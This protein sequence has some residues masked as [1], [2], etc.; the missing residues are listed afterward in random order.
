MSVRCAIF[1]RAGP[2]RAPRG[3]GA[4]ARAG[5]VSRNEKVSRTRRTAHTQTRQ[6]KNLF[7]CFWILR[8]PLFIFF[9]SRG[10]RAGGV[11]RVVLR[12]AAPRPRGQQA[13]GLRPA[14]LGGQTG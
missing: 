5:D 11:D 4:S 8:A 1:K 12:G 3:P 6:K 14:R 9:Y 7:V 13:T 2:A 10:R